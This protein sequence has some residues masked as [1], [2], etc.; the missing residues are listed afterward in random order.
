MSEPRDRHSALNARDDLLAIADAWPDMLER[1]AR[2]G[3]RGG[4]RVSGTSNP[5][6]VLNEAV[7]EAMRELTSWAH[8]LTRVLMDE[9]LD[10]AGRP[11]RPHSTAPADLYAEIA[12]ERVGH[13]TEHPDEMVRLM[14]GDDCRDMRDL[15]T[16]TA[17]PSGRRWVPLPIPC[18]EH[19]TSDLGERVPCPGAYRVLLDPDRPGLVPDMVCS[20]DDQHRVTPVEWQ[21]VSRKTAL[22]PTAAAALLARIRA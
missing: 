21:R 11:W 8:Y 9:V 3:T 6:L 20:E 19:S 17:Y 13:F 16:R 12:R 2:E 22:D 4:E 18:A 15:A 5:G 14:F 7:S 10:A 1:L